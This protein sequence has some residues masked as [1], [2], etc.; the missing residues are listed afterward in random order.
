MENGY[1]IFGYFS[2]KML[3][4]MQPLAAQ[5]SQYDQCGLAFKVN[6]FLQV[7]SLAGTSVLW[8]LQHGESSITCVM[9][10][11]KNWETSILD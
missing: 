3:L 4:H 10:T 8:A 2:L 7:G 1:F 9:D 6:M 11:W 5:L